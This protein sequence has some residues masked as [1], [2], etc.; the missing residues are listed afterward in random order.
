MEAQHMVGFD[1]VK[2]LPPAKVQMGN[3]GAS[4]Y[5]CLQVRESSL[6]NP[7]SV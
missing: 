5:E 7:M 4:F 3:Q 2:M 6:Q 1:H